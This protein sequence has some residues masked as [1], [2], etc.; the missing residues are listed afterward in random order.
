MLRSEFM[1]FSP[2]HLVTD[3]DALASFSACCASDLAVCA[4]AS[5]SS[6]MEMLVCWAAADPLVL[7][8][9]KYFLI[10]PL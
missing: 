3:L 4:E 8:A 9:R 7:S 10:G 6:L 1:R 2:S 5:S